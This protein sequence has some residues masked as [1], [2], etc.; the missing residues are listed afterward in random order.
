MIPNVL[1]FL[2]M[3]VDPEL[4]KKYP[5]EKIE[6]ALDYLSY[7]TVTE[8]LP[9]TESDTKPTLYIFRHGQTTDNAEFVFS[10]WRDPDLTDTGRE[11]A[12]ILAKKIKDKKIDMLVSSP[13]KRAI[14]T[15]KLSISLNDHAKNLTIH[16]DERIKERSYGD[17]QGKSKLEIQLEDAKALKKIRRSYDEIPPNGES[18]AMVVKRVTEFCNE[19]IPLMKKTKVSVAISCHG[20]SMRGFRQYFEKLSN[21]ETALVETPLAQDYAAYVI[22]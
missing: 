22:E 18:L 7:K 11:Q 9:K 20:N 12:L 21:E 1:P 3:N 13:Q 19:I 6:E 16:T 5:K 15:M 17:Y 10:G 2:Y 8:E 4:Y 14:E